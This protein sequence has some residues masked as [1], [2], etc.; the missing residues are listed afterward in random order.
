MRRPSSK[1]EVADG[2]NYAPARPTEFFEIGTKAACHGLGAY[3]TEFIRQGSVVL[4]DGGIAVKNPRL[5]P[6]SFFGYQAMVDEGV[7]L[8]PPDHDAMEATW[9]INHS[10]SPTLARYGGLIYVA[11]RDLQPGEELTV[12]YAPFVAGRDNWAMPCVC[13]GPACR[14]MITSSDWKDPLIARQLWLEWL[15]F[16]QR[17]IQ[18][19]G[20]LGK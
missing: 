7:Y 17:R 11:R 14:E 15:P 20:I 2:A 12:D 10:C 18:L 9:Y 19:L 3:T 1:Y 8:S 4:R 13:R 16:I 6:K 5:L